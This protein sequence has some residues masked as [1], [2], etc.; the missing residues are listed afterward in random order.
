MNQ[1]SIKRY[2]PAT[3]CVK[4][5]ASGAATKF[6]D[7]VMWRQCRNCQYTWQ[8]LPLD[9]AEM[10]PNITLGDLARPAG[11]PQPLVPISRQELF[12]SKVK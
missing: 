12:K 6:E 7:R 5:G 2:D 10:F 9:A 11:E 8:E 1:S 4:C 3:V